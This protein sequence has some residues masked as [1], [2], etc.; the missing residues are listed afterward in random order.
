MSLVG[1]RWR[2]QNGTFPVP[3]VETIHPHTS[4]M[5]HE[6]GLAR[7]NDEEPTES[8]QPALLVRPRASHGAGWGQS[9]A[10]ACVWLPLS[11]VGS[12]SGAASSVALDGVLFFCLQLPRI[13]SLQRIVCAYESC[14]YGL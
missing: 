4:S 13:S 11:A 14:F 3:Q 2:S 1:R 9:R 8:Q 6:L 5:G 7:R 10:A 12:R